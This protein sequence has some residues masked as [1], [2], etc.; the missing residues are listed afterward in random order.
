MSEY[1]SGPGCIGPDLVREAHPT[2]EALRRAGLT[3]VTA[4]SCTGGLIAATLSHGQGASDVLHGGFVVYTKESKTQLLG[5]DRNLL[6]RSG[7]VNEP[8]ARQLAQGALAHSSASV[9]IAVTGVLPPNPD[10]DGNPPGLIFVSVGRRGAAPTVVRL[11]FESRDPDAVRRD[12]VLK[13]LALLR[14]DAAASAPQ[15]R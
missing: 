2:I 6:E 10:E 11:C 1:P 4:E 8:V 7:S 15:A 13:S 9:A 5:V 14:T 12:I 3:V